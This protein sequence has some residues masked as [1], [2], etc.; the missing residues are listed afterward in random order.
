[1]KKVVRPVELLR[2]IRIREDVTGQDLLKAFKLLP[3]VSAIRRPVGY[4][5]RDDLS[6]VILSLS[7]AERSELGLSATMPLPLPSPTPPAP[8]NNY[9]KIRVHAIL[10]ANSDGSGGASDVNAVDAEY[11]KQLVDMTNVIY[12]STALQFVYDPESDFERV[13]SSL[14]NL[15]FTVP[16]GLN[17]SLPESTPPLTNEQILELSQPHADARQQLGRNHCNKLVLLFCDGNMLIYEKDKGIWSIIDRTYAFSGPDL[18]YVTLPT[19]KGD[20]QSFANLVA[21]ETGHYFHQWHTHGAF[22]FPDGLR[23]AR[24]IQEAAD[25]IKTAV[26]KGDLSTADGLKIFDADDSQVHDTPPDA[27]NELFD[28]IYGFYGCGVEDTIQIPVAFA[29][30]SSHEYDLKPDRGNVMSYFKHCVNIQMHFSGDQGIDIKNSI[31][32]GN[33]RHLINAWVCYLS[34]VKEISGALAWAW[35]I[36]IG[37]LMLTPGGITC[38]ACG[39]MLTKVIGVVTVVIGVIGLASRRKALALR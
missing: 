16:D 31:E 6:V 5:D 34:S 35:I 9:Y 7:D 38:I 26:E 36:I 17:Y 33:R 19:R 20:L 37:A 24:T 22:S 15:D 25:I 18:E 27:G 28:T 4:D 8:P 13:N 23:L 2:A 14:L 10:C 29:D 30:G 1:M 3:K 39:F 32:L 12:Q 11:V 21:H